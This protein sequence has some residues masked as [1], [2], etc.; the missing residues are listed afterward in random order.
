MYRTEVYRE[1]ANA[2]IAFSQAESEAGE[3]A[4]QLT[5]IIG[6]RLALEERV[7]KVTR[8]FNDGKIIASVDGIVGATIGLSGETI[9]PGN[10]I[11]EIY[12]TSDLYVDWEMPLRRLIEP[13]VG[14][15]VYIS[16]GYSVIEGTISKIYPI[17]TRLGSERKTNTS[18][19]NQ[20]QTVRVK[21]HGFDEFLALDSQVTVR[22]NYSRVTNRFFNLFRSGFR[23]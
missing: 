19:P 2:K 13:K 11:A 9:T 3:I 5:R 18:R 20:G 22:M 23:T 10:S 16:S 17:S 1:N 15:A 8:E 21:N 7:D 12:E 4:V 14:D 6:N